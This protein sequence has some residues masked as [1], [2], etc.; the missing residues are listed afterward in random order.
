[1]LWAS[2]TF[3]PMDNDQ[4]RDDAPEFGPSGYLPKRAAVRARKIVLRSP[5][6]LQWVV[7]SLVAGIIVVI[8]GV[9]LLRQGGTPPPPPW[10]VAGALDTIEAAEFDPEL[11]ALMVSAGGR[12]RAFEDA[13]D[14]IYCATNNRLEA[15]DGRVWN[16]TGRGLGGAPSL[17]EY[18]TLVHDGVVYVDPTRTSPGPPVSDEPAS[19][20]CL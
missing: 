7:A 2:D 10:V 20:A 1:M 16:L 4:P 11:G 18:P 3:P 15:P 12:I 19:P 6:G 17:D 8:A 14:V 13:N 9:L 5:L